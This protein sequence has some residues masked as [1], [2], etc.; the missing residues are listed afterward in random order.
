MIGNTTDGNDVMN[1][2]IYGKDGNLTDAT[3]YTNVVTF[4]P[5]PPRCRRCERTDLPLLSN[6]L[7]ERCDFV[8]FGYH[9]NP[10]GIAPEGW[11]EPTITPICDE[12]GRDIDAKG[13]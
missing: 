5:P 1:L 8:K 11:P 10:G 13:Q 12:K 7:C 6:G 9:P 2:K 3:E 4:S